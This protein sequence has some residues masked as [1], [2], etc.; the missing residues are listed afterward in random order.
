[1]PQIIQLIAEM[2]DLFRKRRLLYELTKKD[3]Q[4][5]YLGSYLGI[6]WAFIQP[7]I[8]ILIFWFV[9]EVGFKSQ[10]VQDAPFILWLLCGMLPWFY[11]SDS[12]ASATNA[13]VENA[14][15]VKKIVFQVSLLPLVKVITALVVHVFFLGVLFGIFWFYGYSFNV[16]MLQIF[17]Y[18]F[19][20]SI[21]ACGFGYITA[22]LI[23]F[24]R[25]IGQFVGM[26]LQFVFWLT[27]I[28]WAPE[29]L[30]VQYRF[31][32]KLNPVYYI[33]SGY[34][35]S[36][37]YG[38]G[39]WENLNGTIYFWVVAVVVFGVGISVFKKLRPHF[40]DVL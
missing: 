24:L 10:A 1:M 11:I 34:R 16:Y 35:E 25:D 20:A 2:R 40:A 12:I 33:V 15:L 22:A 36:L 8:T 9:F 21:L 30:P 6:C 18:V 39:F 23:V 5:R 27:P 28:F 37:L 13:I 38:H 26:V 7:T 19:A 14:F 3:F 4:V 31:V 17:Y 32:F 29:M